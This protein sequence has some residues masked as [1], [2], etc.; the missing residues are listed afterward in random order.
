MVLLQIVLQLTKRCKTIVKGL[1]RTLPQKLMFGHI[2][3]LL[4][5]G[6]SPDNKAM[7]WSGNEVGKLLTG[8][9]LLSHCGS[10]QYVSLFQHCHS[11]AS[12]SKVRSLQ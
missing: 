10:S 11:L 1:A 12:L 8:Y 9:N 3:A 7:G 5:P 2:Y 6:R 4:F